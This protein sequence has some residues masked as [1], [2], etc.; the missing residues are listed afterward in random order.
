MSS[1]S[2]ETMPTSLSCPSTPS[3]VVAGGSARIVISFS[4][5]ETFALADPLTRIP[6]GTAAEC[7]QRCTSSRNASTTSPPPTSSRAN[8]MFVPSSSGISPLGKQS[9]RVLPR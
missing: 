7:R 1:P 3:S 2:I 4:S 8:A 6:I 5:A 9:I